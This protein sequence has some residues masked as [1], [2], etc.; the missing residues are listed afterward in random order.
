MLDRTEP[1]SDA[2]A[3]VAGEHILSII[4]RVESKR[5]DRKDIDDD[6]KEIFAEA[7]SL[8]FNVPAIKELIKERAVEAND[9][10]RS[11][12]DEHDVIVD[13]YRRAIEAVS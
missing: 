7:K 11:K 6:I 5:E 8:G 2:P 1:L 4:K 13:L 10:K 3:A 12:R 9:S